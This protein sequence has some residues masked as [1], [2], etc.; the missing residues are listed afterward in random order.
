MPDPVLR[1]L[2][3]CEEVE[4]RI[5]RLAQRIVHDYRGRPIL[6]VIIEEGARPFAERLMARVEAQGEK[7][8]R[9]FLRAHRTQGSRLLP[10]QIEALDPLRFKDRDVLLLDDIADEG[11][12]LEAAARLARTGSPRTLR[13]AVLVSKR[14]RRAVELEIDYVAFEVD[15]GWVVGVGMDLDGRFR[16]LD[17]LAVVEGTE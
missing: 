10:V 3:S 8:E 15:V 16:E 14:V 1:E 11:R 6:G 4:A 2:Y 5:D 13:M 9:L 7:V 17:H 12:T